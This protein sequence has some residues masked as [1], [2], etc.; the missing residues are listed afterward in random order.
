MDKEKHIAQELAPVAVAGDHEGAVDHSLRILS[1]VYNYNHWIYSLLRGYVGD[2]VLEVGA[3][4]G[5]I[6]RFLLHVE[7]LT[8]LEPADEYRKFLEAKVADHKNTTVVGCPIEDCPNEDVKEGGYDT[9]VCLNV[10]EHIENDVDALKSMR[11]TLGEGGK[12]VIVVPA[13]QVAYGA[14]DRAMDHCRRYSKGV[15]SQR[16]RDAGFD[17][18][19]TR[20][21]NFP[22]LF[23]WWWHGRIL[24]ST[25]IPEGGTRLFDRLVPFLSGVE[26]IFHPPVGQSLI[27]VGEKVEG[28]RRPEG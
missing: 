27:V 23:G 21:F 11:A 25:K 16:M 4:I 28:R 24:K 10:L 7:K 20:Y 13:M 14:L 17:V 1:T 18:I 6:S 2:K 5:N 8:C 9:V 12:C 22:G 15:L 19:H 26:S 3:G